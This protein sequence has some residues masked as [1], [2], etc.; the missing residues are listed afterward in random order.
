MHSTAERGSGRHRD[1]VERLR[2]NWNLS[3][4]EEGRAGEIWQRK[5]VVVQNEEGDAKE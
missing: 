1:V 3:V 4:K 2:G 5:N